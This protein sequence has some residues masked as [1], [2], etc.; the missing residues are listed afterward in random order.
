LTIIT[1]TGHH[2]IGG[3]SESRLLPKVQELLNYLNYTFKLVKDNKGYTGGLRV[4][5]H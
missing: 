5:L 4:K 2:T 1:G 3:N